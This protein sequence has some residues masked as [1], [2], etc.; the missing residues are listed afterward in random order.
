M[1]ET[2][3]KLKN[4][5]YQIKTLVLKSGK[6]K[7]LVSN[8]IASRSSS[9]KSSSSLS[10]FKK[11]VMQMSTL[12][13]KKANRDFVNFRRY[14]FVINNWKKVIMAI[15]KI[16]RVLNVKPLRIPQTSLQFATSMGIGI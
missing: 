5:F 9:I 13:F 10:N 4:T 6:N 15:K 14:S 11:L 1:A 3:K 2:F 16:D 8:L 7:S 12:Q